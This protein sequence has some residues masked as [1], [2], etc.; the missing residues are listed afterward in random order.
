M[1]REIEEEKKSTLVQIINEVDELNDDEKRFVLYWLRA[2]KNAPIAAAADRTTK[3]NKIAVADI[4][5]ERK[6]AR[7]QKK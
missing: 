5:K 4:Y 7:K 6:A 1:L 2:K 3:P